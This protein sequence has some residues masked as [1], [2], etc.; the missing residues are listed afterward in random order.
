[1]SHP[2]ACSMQDLAANCGM[3]RPLDSLYWD[4]GSL[5]LPG[6]S[7]LVGLQLEDWAESDVISIN[8]SLTRMGCLARLEQPTPHLGCQD[9]LP[10]AICAQQPV[11]QSS[12]VSS[13]TAD[14]KNEVCSYL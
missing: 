10:G 5:I 1:M 7:P 13:S 2:L 3:W 14:V 6:A 9:T 11:C 8:G 12:L 4:T